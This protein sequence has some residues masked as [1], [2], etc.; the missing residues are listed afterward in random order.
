[1]VE[2]A[3]GC[4]ERM[5]V[6]SMS[7]FQVQNPY[8]YIGGSSALAEGMLDVISDDHSRYVGCINISTSKL[9]KLQRKLRAQGEFI[10]TNQFDF[11]LTNRKSMAMIEACKKMNITPLCTNVLDGGL[12]SGKYTSVNPT[13][14]E[15]SKGEGDTG[16]YP[17]RTLEKLDVLFKVQDSLRGKVN[18]R[19]G[20][21]LLK[22]ESGQAVRMHY[23]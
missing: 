7:L 3:E 10:A 9:A 20:D 4:C 23:I 1:L 16:P 8:F 6:S 22:Y 14:G 21:K 15:V 12:A 2:A 11:S 19:I 18:S 13:G 17:L 5:G